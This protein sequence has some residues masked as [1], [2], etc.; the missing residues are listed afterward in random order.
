MKA[1]I[2]LF[3]LSL[4]SLAFAADI[5]ADQTCHEAQ[6]EKAK[7]EVNTDSTREPA[8]ATQTQHANGYDPIGRIR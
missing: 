6:A 4:T 7:H 3:C 8:T 2:V 1:F 5:P